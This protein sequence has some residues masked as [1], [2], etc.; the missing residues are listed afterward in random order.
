MT[1]NDFPRLYPF[2]LLCQH[3][4][5]TIS[6]FLLLS[7]VSVLL[8][9]RESLIV[10]KTNFHWSYIFLFN[11]PRQEANTKQLSSKTK[12]HSQQQEAKS[13]RRRNAVSE[14]DSF[15]RVVTGTLRWLAI[16]HCLLYFLA[17]DWLRQTGLFFLYWTVFPFVKESPIWNYPNW[18]SIGQFVKIKG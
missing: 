14:L 18:S 9:Y 2:V 3:L 15:W 16:V 4:N 13:F 6:G 10:S 5:T 7:K 11:W 17:F 8:H 1:L 12:G